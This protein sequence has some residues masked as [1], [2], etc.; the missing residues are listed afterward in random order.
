M[1]SKLW[2]DIDKKRR[3]S[4]EKYNK[5][6]FYACSFTSGNAI[7]T[8]KFPAFNLNGIDIISNTQDIPVD[9]IH[10]RFDSWLPD[11]ENYKLIDDIRFDDDSKTLDIDGIKHHII[12]DTELG[13]FVQDFGVSLSQAREN[14]MNHLINNIL[15]K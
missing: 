14:I 7:L 3:L 9:T 11:I 5:I 12:D 6:D 10:I 13:I 8:I 1:N 2:E 4:G 15:S